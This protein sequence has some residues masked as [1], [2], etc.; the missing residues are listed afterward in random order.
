MESH[1]RQPKKAAGKEA[2]RCR[3]P[4]GMRVRPALRARGASRQAHQG[5]LALYTPTPRPV[6]RAP[7]QGERERRPHTPGNV[8]P[9]SDFPE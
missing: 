9:R 5:A 1:W 8:R 6:L 3:G 4:G 7:G 2:G